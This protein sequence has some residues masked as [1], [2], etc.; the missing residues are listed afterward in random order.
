MISLVV[1][2]WVLWT[3]PSIQPHLS[4]QPRESWS[5]AKWK[6][7]LT[8]R[9]R[10]LSLASWQQ[11]CITQWMISLLPLSTVKPF[12]FLYIPKL[13]ILGPSVLA[14]G[15]KLMQKY[16]KASCHLFS[17]FRR[18]WYW[19]TVSVYFASNWSLVVLLLYFCLNILNNFTW[20]FK[21]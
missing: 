19:I 4:I 16:M 17:L 9:R 2:T 18:N 20:K 8:I 14:V 10:F 11:Y 6:L 7:S 3:R 13:P 15:T 12:H 5:F 1:V 21:I